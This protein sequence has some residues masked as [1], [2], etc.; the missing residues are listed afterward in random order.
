[1]ERKAM[2][3]PYQRCNSEQ[4]EVNAEMFCVLR[5]RNIPVQE[6]L[7]KIQNL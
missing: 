3:K 4:L 2:H 1:M 6:K 7:E 5:K